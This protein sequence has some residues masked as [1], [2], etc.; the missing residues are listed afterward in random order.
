MA[1][2]SKRDEAD[3]DPDWEKG[4]CELWG[5]IV[6]ARTGAPLVPLKRLTFCAWAE[7]MDKG[8]K[9]ALLLSGGPT[10]GS[11]DERKP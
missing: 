1:E 4:S 11:G 3:R 8:A 2:S 5:I 7:A 10:G 6:S 9:W